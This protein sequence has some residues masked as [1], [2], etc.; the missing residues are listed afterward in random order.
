M[1]LQLDNLNTVNIPQPCRAVVRCAENLA[2]I[3]AEL[4]M[5]DD[6]VVNESGDLCLDCETSQRR[7]LPSR[8]ATTRRLPSGLNAASVSKL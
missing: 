3:G 1:T 5:L 2:A 4:D 6:I 7:T 8:D